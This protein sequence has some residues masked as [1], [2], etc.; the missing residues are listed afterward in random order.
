M[1]ALALLSKQIIKLCEFGCVAIEMLLKESFMNMDIRKVLLVVKLWSILIIPPVIFMVLTVIQARSVSANEPLNFD[2]F[3]IDINNSLGVGGSKTAYPVTGPYHSR[4]N[5][6]GEAVMKLPNPNLTNPMIEFDLEMSSLERLE[7]L[8]LRTVPSYRGNYYGEPAI[9]NPIR[10]QRHS[11]G[12]N[13]DK[14]SVRVMDTDLLMATNDELAK[15]IGQVGELGIGI[16]DTQFGERYGLLYMCDPGEVRVGDPLWT[17]RTLVTLNMSKK[18]IQNEL[19]RRGGS[20]SGSIRPGYAGTLAL[21]AVGV[22]MSASDIYNGYRADGS[23]FG[24]NAQLA[25]GRQLGGWVG[26]GLGGAGG[27]ALAGAATG[28]VCGPGA[29]VCSTVLAAGGALVGGI[30]GS[31]YG[32]SLGESAVGF[33]QMMT[34]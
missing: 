30:A 3:G 4:L 7:G 21:S 25:T 34:R 22:S 31:V 13:F 23:R 9:I 28:L 11:K 8:G 2:P 27:G 33:G 12:G 1:L 10:F 24:T 20:Q 18:R 5:P 19:L 29:P 16:E 6:F 14:A 32:S 17:N 15:L 26:G